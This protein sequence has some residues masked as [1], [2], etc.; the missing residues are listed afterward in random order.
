MHVF[1]LFFFDHAAVDSGWLLLSIV[2]DHL[3]GY[4][5]GDVL[6]SRRVVVSRL[7][8]E[9][10]PKGPSPSGNLILT[11]VCGFAS[12][13]RMPCLPIMGSRVLHLQHRAVCV[14]LSIPF[15]SLC[16]FY[17]WYMRHVELDFIHGEG[18]VVCHA[19]GSQKFQCKDVLIFARMHFYIYIITT[20]C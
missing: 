16:T 5:S 1:S 10:E 12:W 14:W 7:Q 20:T 9:G 17:H 8:T 11:A 15:L 3:D 13:R 4:L 19:R 6:C 2:Q 18:T